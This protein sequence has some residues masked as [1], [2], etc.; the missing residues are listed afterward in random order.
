MSDDPNVVWENTIDGGVWGAKV[1]RTADHQGRLTVWNV[2]SGEAILSTEVG[3]AY[4]ALFG[5]D[6]DD[7]RYWQHAILGAIDAQ[8]DIKNEDG[9]TK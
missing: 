8:A 1:V 6:A 5:P 7:L 9:V 4:D 2:A 3:L